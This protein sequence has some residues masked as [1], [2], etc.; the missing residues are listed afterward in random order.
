MLAFYKNCA[1]IVTFIGIGSGF[2]Y[3]QRS[4][5]NHLFELFFILTASVILLLFFC[6]TALGDMVLLHRSGAE[7]YIWVGI[8]DI[9]DPLVNTLMDVL[10]LSFKFS[11]S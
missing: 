4:P 10:F 9:K 11:A 8:I 3:Q 7:E 1:F 5:N 2:A 6:R